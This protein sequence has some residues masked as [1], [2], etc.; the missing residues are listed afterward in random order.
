MN[1]RFTAFVNRV[2]ITWSSDRHP[3]LEDFKR[4]YVVPGP[5][6]ENHSVAY[7]KRLSYSIVIPVDQ[8]QLKKGM[9]YIGVLP[10]TDENNQTQ[11]TREGINISYEINILVAKCVYWSVKNRSWSTEGCK[12]IICSIAYEIIG[13]DPGSITNTLS[14]FMGLLIST[15]I[16]YQL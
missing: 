6:F 4:K 5:K 16:N 9:N 2:K 3:S 10:S 12:V 13:M 7:S 15:R 8:H 14:T 11:L 1:I